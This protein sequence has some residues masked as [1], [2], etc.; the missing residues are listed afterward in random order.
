MS[1]SISVLIKP[2]SSDAYCAG[3]KFAKS[4]IDEGVARAMG[5]RCI[6]V[7][8]KSKYFPQIYV[9]KLGGRYIRSTEDLKG[10]V[11]NHGLRAHFD[12]RERCAAFVKVKLIVRFYRLTYPLGTAY[13][14]PIFFCPTTQSN[15]ASLKVHISP[16]VATR[17]TRFGSFY[18]RRSRQIRERKVLFLLL[19]LLLLLLLGDLGGLFSDLPCTNKMGASRENFS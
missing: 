5:A 9:V 3:G 11:S 13:I 7:F 17:I 14:L 12:P 8:K 1:Y 2:L 16:S 18:L 15:L 19:L 6:F 10:F 4:V